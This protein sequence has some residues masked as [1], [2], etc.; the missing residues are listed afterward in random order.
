M[1][2]RFFEH[3]TA[4]TLSSHGAAEKGMSGTIKHCRSCLQSALLTDVNTVRRNFS[5]D[6]CTW[7]RQTLSLLGRSMELSGSS[8]LSSSSIC[9]PQ[10][11]LVTILSSLALSKLLVTGM[12][13]CAVVLGTTPDTEAIGSSYPH[14]SSSTSEQTQVSHFSTRSMASNRFPI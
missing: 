7:V 11:S 2:F 3:S 12:K 5:V 10:V 6:L 4:I 8:V 14:F 1:D 13:V 9:L